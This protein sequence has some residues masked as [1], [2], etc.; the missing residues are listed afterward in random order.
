MS[1]RA[2][3]VFNEPPYDPDRDPEAKAETDQFA[4]AGKGKKENLILYIFNIV[5]YVIGGILC[6]RVVPKFGKMFDEM[7]FP[8]PKHTSII[9]SIPWFGYLAVSLAAVLFIVVIQIKMKNQIVKNTIF[10]ISIFLCLITV[11]YVMSALFAPLSGV[12]IQNIEVR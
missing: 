9:V 1:N 8:L 10:T 5:L 11:A 3:K 6:I 12:I 2:T 4:S 7:N